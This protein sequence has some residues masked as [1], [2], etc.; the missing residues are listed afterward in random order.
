MIVAVMCFAAMNL[1]LDYE[2]HAI[3][4]GYFM[5]IFHQRYIL[6]IPFSF[7]S[8]YKEPWALLGFAL[9]LT[10]NGKRGRQYKIINYCFY[11][12]HLLIL[13]LLRLY[14]GI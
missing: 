9:T 12:A 5:Y 13:G 8:M 14:L 7:L 2:H 10:Y 4:I 3:L 1:G 6:S 11:P